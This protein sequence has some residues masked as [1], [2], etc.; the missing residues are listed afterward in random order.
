MLC[1]RKSSSKFSPCKSRPVEALTNFDSIVKM[2]VSA[3]VIHSFGYDHPQDSLTSSSGDVYDFSL[4]ST[5]SCGEF[6]VFI[7]YIDF[8]MPHIVSLLFFTFGMLFLRFLGFHCCCKLQKQVPRMQKEY[9]FRYL[10]TWKMQP[11]SQ[12]SLL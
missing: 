12:K 9:R 4:Q 3:S 11:R 1:G 5:W 2:E 6:V 8:P 10:L 7:P